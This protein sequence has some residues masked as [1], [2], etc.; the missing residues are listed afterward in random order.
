LRFI[1]IYIQT[2]IVLLVIIRR[3]EKPLQPVSDKLYR[4][5]TWIIFIIIVT[6][7]NTNLNENQKEKDFEICAVKIN[8]STHTMKS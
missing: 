5:S 7:Y 2:G 8:S 1:Q 6:F 4:I 3:V